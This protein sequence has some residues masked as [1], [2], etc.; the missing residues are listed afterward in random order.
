MDVRVIAFFLLICQIFLSCVKENRDPFLVN[1]YQYNWEKHESF[2]SKYQ[3]FNMPYTDDYD[4]N[5]EHIGTVEMTEASGLAYSRVNPGMVWAHNDSGHPNVLFLLDGETGEVIARYTIEGSANVD[6]EDMEIAIDPEDNIS[7]VYVADTG[8][9]HERRPD[10][11]V[12]KFKEPV[13]HPDHKGLN[14]NYEDPGLERFR[15]R[16]PDG[17]HDTEAMFVD[18]KTRDIYLVTKRDVVSFLY[19]IPYPQTLGEIY[20]IYKVGEFSFREASAGSV[21]PD[22]DRIMIKNRQDIFYWTRSEGER[23]MDLLA[24]TPVRAPYV[25]EPQGEAICFDE[26]GNYFTLSEQTNQLVKPILYKYFLNQ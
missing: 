4:F 16:Y 14:N 26:K 15:F 6:W 13:F 20:T 3:V 9:N 19:V 10:Y 5:P 24:R 11:S 7:Y 1:K 23:M 17:S 18:P 2:Q 22:G 12:Y 25:G 8:D 21:S